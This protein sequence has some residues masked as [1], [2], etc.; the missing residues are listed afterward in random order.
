MDEVDVARDGGADHSLRPLMAI[1]ARSAARPVA[2][3]LAAFV[4]A[5]LVIL[6][7]QPGV[8]SA[9]S[10]A[11]YRQAT[12]GV[13]SDWHPPLMAH[14]WAL[15]LNVAPGP[16][17]ILV[18]HQGLFWA[19][20]AL[21]VLSLRFRTSA[22]AALVLVVGLVPSVFG[23][24]GV[25]WKDV[26]MGAALMLAVG[27]ILFGRRIGS[28]VLLAGAFLP[29]L[30]AVSMRYNALP[31]V[32]PLVAWMVYEVLRL[33]S[34]PSR[35]VLAIA[36]SGLVMTML[37][38]QLLLGAGVEYSRSWRGTGTLQASLIHD[39]SG[40]AVRT[41]E[42]R[43]PAHV[44]QGDP[45]ITV[46]LLRELYR[47][48]SLNEIFFHEQLRE[49]TVTRSGSEVLELLRT[50]W[51]TVRSSPVAY[52]EHRLGVLGTLFGVTKVYYPF[53]EGIETNDQGLVFHRS[54]VYDA[55]V[56]GLHATEWPFY[57]GW[58]YLLGALLI[59]VT[60]IVGRRSRSTLIAVSGI[61]YALPYTFISTGSD[62]RYIWWLV[63]A[64]ILAAIVRLDE[65]RHP[66][67]HVKNVMAQPSGADDVLFAR[68][69]G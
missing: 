52:I 35:K 41:G 25:I 2:V 27:M 36:S 22:S 66:E 47:P 29:L 5:L 4:G 44:L 49:R 18:W 9:D 40:I 13:F 19:G 42:V 28:P 61:A 69:P 67:G 1:T 23:L 53:H 60:G 31:A 11:Q 37:L 50:W 34:M 56:G 68:G 17:G 54:A 12:T 46:D 15:L 3:A 10:L 55:V 45:P 62:F 43:F 38:T 14:T 58:I 33:R 64:T 48:E 8:M 57:R 16:F 39:L 20:L 21:A 51:E 59:V 63:L 32:I 6:V 65:V 7:Y 26:G 30:Y 24:L